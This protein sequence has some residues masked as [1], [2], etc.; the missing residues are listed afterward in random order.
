VST[1]PQLDRSRVAS[2]R[3][4]KIRAVGDPQP[5]TDAALEAAK[6]PI[7]WRFSSDSLWRSAQ[8]V[9]RLHERDVRYGRAGAS[10]KE[11]HEV[12]LMAVIFRHRHSAPPPPV[13]HVYMMLA[14]L[15]LEALAKGLLVACDPARVAP[16]HAEGISI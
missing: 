7:A 15:S 6:D 2:D 4:A 5:L 10:T 1:G 14:G 13:A 8:V 11:T 12:R 16:S 9:R 3:E